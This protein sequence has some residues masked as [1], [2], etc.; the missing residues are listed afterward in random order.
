M[1]TFASY[2]IV[3]L[4]AAV[5][6]PAGIVAQ[7]PPPNPAIVRLAPPAFSNLSRAI[8]RYLERRG[9]RIPQSFARKDPHNVIRGRFTRAGQVDTAVLCSNSTSSS[10]LVFRGGTTSDVA[11]LAPQPDSTFLQAI[12]ARGNFGY[13][14]EVEVASA[15]H[16]RQHHEEFGGAE[17][18]DRIDHDGLEDIFV[19][20]ASIIWYWDAAQWLMLQGSD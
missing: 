5:P 6:T 12:D 4:L 10:I 8:R 20:K 18:P 3:S 9:C 2:A 1:K 14:R 16:I 11:E 19:E 13:S 7:E 17:P 15:S